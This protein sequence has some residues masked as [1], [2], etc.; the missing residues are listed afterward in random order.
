MGLLDVEFLSIL[1][2]Q[3]EEVSLPI[4]NSILIHFLLQECTSC[5][6][7]HMACVRMWGV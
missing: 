7:K 3:T 1:L 4:I 6:E 2:L 5:S